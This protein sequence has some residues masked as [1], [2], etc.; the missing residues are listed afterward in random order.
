MTRI[1]ARPHI[2]VLFASLALPL[3]QAIPARGGDAAAP[4]AIRSVSVFKN[5]LAFVV[6]STTLPHEARTVNIGQL[7]IPSFGTFWVSYPSGVRVQG[8][9][10]SMS[11]MEKRLPAVS[12]GQLLRA[13]PGRRVIVHTGDRDIEGT[14]LPPAVGDD[15][16]RILSPYVMSPRAA[17]APL[18]A[19]SDVL[20]IRTD[21][22]ITAINAGS[23]V[24]AEFAD[25]DVAGTVAY[26]Y[27]SPSVRIQLAEPAGGETVTVSCLVHGLTWVPG[28][29]IDLTDPK[30]ASVSAHAEIINELADIDDVT[31]QLVT[32]FPSA[33]FSD[34]QSPLAM[35]Q[36]LAGFLRSLAVGSLPQ[37]QRGSITSQMLMSNS[38]GG[39]GGDA[40][41]PAPSYSTA[42]EGTVAED[43]FFY[44]VKAFTLKKDETAWIPLFTAE[45]P[46]KHIYTW[47][48]GDYLDEQDHYRVPAEPQA[49][50][51]PEEV[52]HACR[53]TNTLKMPLT[54]AS[55]EF[56]TGGTFTG[57]DVC[58]Y[59]PAGTETTIRI[60]KALNIIAEQAEVELERKRDASVIHGYH[61][62]VVK[63]RGDLKLRSRVDRAVNVEI[64]KECS[65]DVLES[66][67][68]AKDVKTARGLRQVNTR[69]VLTWIVALDPGEER[70][71]TYQ[72]QVLIRE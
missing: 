45:M 42:S 30:K 36:D 63:L 24:R 4:V 59:T 53:L 11:E 47:K 66:S 50:K 54:T 19:G 17:E 40:L 15:A 37:V 3:F 68:S 71:V 14:I 31:L 56:M 62:D 21:R 64:T 43:L 20:M 57:Q 2:P 72:Y 25:H 18:P 33:K 61:Y 29:L 52:W 13:N 48:I 10:S 1:F 44:P 69:H 16:S 12:I 32:G 49:E 58:Y 67:P 55:A 51:S 9:V 38:V 46:Y 26:R 34:L 7:P 39:F 41:A 27:K 60:N 22:G 65:G 35:S 6:S 5:G 8:L 70:T 23:A 28:Y